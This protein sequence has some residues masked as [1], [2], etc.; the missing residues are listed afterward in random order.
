MVVSWLKSNTWIFHN[1]Y[2]IYD[3]DIIYFPFPN[4]GC[5]NSNLFRK[6]FASFAGLSTQDDRDSHSHF[7]RTIILIILIWTSYTCY[8][9][10]LIGFDDDNGIPLPLFFTT[11]LVLFL[12]L[13]SILTQLSFSFLSFLIT[14]HTRY[15]KICPS[16][17]QNHPEIDVPDVPRKKR[18]C[19][20]QGGA[21]LPA[22]GFRGGGWGHSESGELTPRTVLGGKTSPP[23]P[24]FGQLSFHI[25]RTLDV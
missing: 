10:I 8:T 22:A 17:G 14:R 15:T 2:N 6:R 7:D 11:I 13:L 23:V 21:R 20:V 12:S 4:I 9:S 18:H 3:C 5:L 16:P 24:G 1:I 25:F 19:R